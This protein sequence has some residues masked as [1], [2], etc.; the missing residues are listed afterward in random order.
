M[1][2]G[3]ALPII[4]QRFEFEAGKEVP[5]WICLTTIR[6][7]RIIFRTAYDVCALYQGDCGLV[8]GDFPAAAFETIQRKAVTGLLYL[9]R[10]HSTGDPQW[11]YP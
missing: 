8:K 1:C 11:T 3:P 5:E 4:K 2:D 10:H 9:A 7:P 6:F